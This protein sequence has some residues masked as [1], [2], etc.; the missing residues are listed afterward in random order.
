MGNAKA[1]DASA[2]CGAFVQLPL[3]RIKFKGLINGQCRQV[4]DT[5]AMI[6]PIPRLLVEIGRV[7]QLEVGDLVFTGT[8]AGVGPLAPGDSLVAES[9]L[10]GRFEWRMLGG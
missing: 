9:A 3:Q 7:W 2:P 8:P 1:F 5:D 4:G 6:F 10:L